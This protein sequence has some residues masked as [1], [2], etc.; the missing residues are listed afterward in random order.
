[1]TT[2]GDIAGHIGTPLTG[3]ATKVLLLGAGELGKQLVIAF[4]NLGLEV[5]A[6]DRYA[7]A[8]AQQLAHFSYIA[9]IRDPH[10]V[11]ELTERI[12]PDYVVPEVET[13]AVEALKRIEEFG[14]TVV[15][16]ARACELTQCRESVREVAESIGLPVTAYRF[17]ESAEELKEAVGELGLPCI[18]KPDITTSGKGHVLLKEEEDVEEAWAMVRHVSSDNKRVVVERFVDFDYEVTLL[19]VRSI[20]PATG[21]MATWFS[22]PIGHRHENGDLVES[23]QPMAMS[24]DALANARSVAARISNELGGRGVYGVELFVAGDEVYFSSVSPRPLDTAMLTGYTQRFSEFELHVRAIL[25]FPIDVTMVSPGAAVI[26]HA[27]AELD[28]VSFTGL[29]VALSYEE[30]DVRLFGKPWAYAGRRMGMVATT[31]EDVE[32]A[33]DRAALAAG[34]IT[35]GPNADRTV[36][37]DSQPVEPT[38]NAASDIELIEVPE[39]VVDVDPKLIRSTDD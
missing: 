7:G 24:E 10:K 22:E 19:A 31:A 12:K 21:K 32:T 14:T 34:K 16:T 8:P 17:A 23:W 38:A 35:V 26:L 3:N 29:D 11:W 39:P 1:M 2:V 13:V 28:D 9:D 36:H 30:T 20:D 15:P 5:H 4:Q 25:G 6:V 27:D 33:R 37:G 18:V